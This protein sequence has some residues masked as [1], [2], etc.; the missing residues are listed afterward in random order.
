V[1]K[2]WTDTIEAH[3]R[4]VRETVLAT[5]GELVRERGLRAVTMSAIAERAGIGRATLY[6]YFPD[7][8]AA[9]RAWH[10]RAIAEHVD[11]LARA[12]DAEEDP[13]RR[14]RGVLEAYALIQ[15]RRFAHHHP[16]STFAETLHQ[17]A[18]VAQA[19]EHVHRLIATALAEVAEAGGLRDDVPID[20]LA[21][22]C[23]HSLSSAACL[24][25][26]DA[27][28]RLVAVVLTGLRP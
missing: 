19:H 25:S 7:V 16:G 26:E 13:E 21:S 2:L 27:A 14:L 9:L 15:R 10:E 8:E 23:L 22:F 4:E 5:V 6:K 18:H 12:R 20:E 17:S 24:P 1:P 28:R 11:Q 3:R